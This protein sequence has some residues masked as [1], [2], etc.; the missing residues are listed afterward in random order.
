VPPGADPKEQAVR[1][2]LGF[3]D[4]L[5]DRSPLAVDL[6]VRSDARSA[7]KSQAL[8]ALSPLYGGRLDAGSKM[9]LN[10]LALRGAPSE[11]LYRR[12]LAGGAGAVR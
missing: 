7:E 4:C 3:A 11:Q 8:A 1:V 9:S 5:I 10:R 6:M 12:A 2:T